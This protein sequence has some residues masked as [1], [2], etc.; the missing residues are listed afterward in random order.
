MIFSGRAETAASLGPPLVGPLQAYV[1]PVLAHTSL[2]HV[3]RLSIK[4]IYL[5]SD[6][7]AQLK[8]GIGCPSCTHLR[9]HFN[10]VSDT[11]GQIS[12]LANLTTLTNHFSRRSALVSIFICIN[13]PL[14]DMVDPT[15]S[16]CR[17]L[18]LFL[19]PLNFTS[20]QRLEVVG[21]L[22]P[23]PGAAQAL[24][25]PPAP[26]RLQSSAIDKALAEDFRLFVNA[27]ST[28]LDVRLRYD[29]MVSVDGSRCLVM[30]R[31]AGRDVE[32]YSI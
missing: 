7:N 3:D 13:Q 19:D 5:A 8:L 20:L 25:L 17:Q 28:D 10:N 14:E 12:L 29:K 15:T 24:G 18:R 32:V 4:S 30:T 23:I 6:H 21:T 26:A 16:F 2:R 22:G 9:L 27:A 1:D 11:T 31:K